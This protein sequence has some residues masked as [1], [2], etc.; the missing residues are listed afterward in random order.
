MTRASDQRPTRRVVSSRLDGDFVLEV[1]EHE[2]TIRPKGSRR[3][4]P[5]EVIVTY[6]L[7]YQRELVS[8][9]EEKRRAKIR[10]RRIRR[11]G[12]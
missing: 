7:I 12:R 10:A 6:G 8:R 11:G 3:R 1:G 5:A 2:L 9:V 4:G